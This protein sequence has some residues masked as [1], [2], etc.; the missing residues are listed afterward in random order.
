VGRP[1]PATVDPIGRRADRRQM[2]LP[3]G[4]R[5]RRGDRRRHGA[6]R[7]GIREAD[8]LLRRGAE[9][10]VPAGI[11]LLPGPFPATG[12]RSTSTTSG[13]SRPAAPSAPALAAMAIPWDTIGDRRARTPRPRADKL[14][15]VRAVAS[16]M[17]EFGERGGPASGPGR[18][19]C[20]PASGAARLFGTPIGQTEHAVGGR[21]RPAAGPAWS[22]RR[23]NHW[24]RLWRAV[25]LARPTTR[26]LAWHLARCAPRAPGA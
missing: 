7:V 3:G 11:A 19:A 4:A 23:P 21:G 13:A 14:M 22:G 1:Q 25:S 12:P 8:V 2:P 5:H 26:H 18:R 16:G 9:G 24:A 17:G 20:R 15:G 6:P 10:Q